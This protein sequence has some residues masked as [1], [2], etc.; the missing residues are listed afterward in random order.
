LSVLPPLCLQSCTVIAVAST[1]TQPGGLYEVGQFMNSL[2]QQQLTGGWTYP[3]GYCVG[4]NEAL[5]WARYVCECA[6]SFG[7]FC[8]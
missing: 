7:Q 5:D 3:V 4:W 6:A 8:V 1:I 2:V